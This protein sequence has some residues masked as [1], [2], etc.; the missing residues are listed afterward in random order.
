MLSLII[1]RQLF[2]PKQ[3]IDSQ[4]KRVALAGDPFH[5]LVHVLRKKE[6]EIVDTFDGEG[7][8][9]RA[10]IQSV[11]EK[12]A[13]LEIVEEK[14][15]SAQAG[16]VLTLGAALLKGKKMNWL[17]QKVTEAGVHAIVPLITRR[18]IAQASGQKAGKW[19]KVAVEASKQC[20]R[21]FVPPIHPP[22]SWED[23]LSHAM[24]YDAKLLAWETQGGRSGALLRSWVQSIAPRMKA[25][26]RLWKVLL[27]VG[28]EGGFDVSEVD[29]ARRHGFVTFG[30]GANILR[31]E[32]AALIASALVMYELENASCDRDG[33]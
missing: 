11:T 18:T 21:V 22:I 30:L 24:E 31:S 32:T 16:F 2:I 15:M 9:Y 3:W 28:P 26:N 25:Q 20:G 4:R 7:G 29:A 10:R 19:E 23:F 8:A 13:V 33:Y 5:H 14:R 6:G 1:M 17:V 27:A 12:N